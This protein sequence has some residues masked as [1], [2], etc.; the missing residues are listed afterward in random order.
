MMEALTMPKNVEVLT[1]AKHKYQPT[2]VM[3]ENVNEKKPFE[4][5]ALSINR[6]L[7]RQL[8]NL[9]LSKP[10]KTISKYNF[11]EKKNKPKSSNCIRINAAFLKVCIVNI[12]L[13]SR[14]RKYSQ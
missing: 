9:T 14:I 8:N 6:E 3:N 2:K 10:E 5:Q 12:I 7:Q 1:R 13:A 11:T 4:S